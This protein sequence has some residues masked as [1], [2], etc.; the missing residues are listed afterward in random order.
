[1]FEAH[2]Q[3]KDSPCSSALGNLLDYF[4]GVPLKKLLWSRR[5]A[6]SRHELFQIMRLLIPLSL[7]TFS[8]LHQ[9]VKQ[10]QTHWAV[11]L[12]TRPLGS[13]PLSFIP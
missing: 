9:I 2:R 11:A 4:S 13:S 3:T 5:A 1:M 10:K 6:S 7:F 12:P 8:D